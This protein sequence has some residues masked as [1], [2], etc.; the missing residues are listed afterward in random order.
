[1]ILIII[2]VATLLLIY[3]SNANQDVSLIVSSLAFYMSDKGNNSFYSNGENPD[4]I[5]FVCGLCSKIPDNE[6]KRLC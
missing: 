4:N 6:L 5:S 3:I 2:G 1:M